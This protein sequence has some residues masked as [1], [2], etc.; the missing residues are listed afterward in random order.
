MTNTQTHTQS[1]YSRVGQGPLKQAFEGGEGPGG[2]S[3]PPHTPAPHAAPGCPSSR[4]PHLRSSNLCPGPG[5]CMS[6]SF[7]SLG[8]WPVRARGWVS[9]TGRSAPCC[10]GFASRAVCCVWGEHHELGAL[11]PPPQGTWDR[12]VQ[13]TPLTAFTLDSLQKHISIFDLR[14]Y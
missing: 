12:G 9:W 10:S 4:G 7:V 2:P 1:K 3:A 5:V 11:S 14:Y 13:D 6:E 8:P